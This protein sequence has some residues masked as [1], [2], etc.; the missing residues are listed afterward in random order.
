MALVARGST[1]RGAERT[2][3]PDAP[4]TPDPAAERTPDPAAE[5]TTD[6]DAERTREPAAERTTDPD[7]ECTTEPAAE[8]T[9]APAGER[10]T[11][12][13]GDRPAP[14]ASAKRAARK[15][16]RAARLFRFDRDFGARFVAGADEAGRGSLAGPLVAAGVLIDYANLTLRDRRA[17]GYLDDSKQRSCDEREALYPVVI[18]AAARVS[19]TVRCVRGIDARG[20]HRT[21]LAALARSLERVAVPGAVCLTDGFRAPQ[22]AVAHEAVIDGDARS[23]AIAAASVIAKVTR[24]RYMHRVADAYPGFGFDGN[25]GYSTPEH[26]AAIVERGP[27]SLHRRSFASIA[28]SQ[29]RLG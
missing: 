13:G 21:N 23:A 19:V 8:R 16:R 11:T 4:R 2:T 7:T 15:R 10:R 22:C 5:R 17:L 27:S 1:A 3:D 28:Y 12:D 20:L 18:R 24:D 14:T 25:V 9:T 29:L 6:P 26:R